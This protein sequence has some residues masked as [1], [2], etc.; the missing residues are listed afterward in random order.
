MPSV[1]SAWLPSW[2]ARKTERGGEEREKRKR[3]K[4]RERERRKGEAAPANSHPIM[5]RV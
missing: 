5:A 2:H 4:G 3:K 1:P